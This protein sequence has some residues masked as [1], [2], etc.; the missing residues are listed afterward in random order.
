MAL[1]DGLKQVPEPMLTYHPSCSLSNGHRCGMTF[2][3]LSC[4]SACN[5]CGCAVDKAGLA[6][7]IFRCNYPTA[8][9]KLI[10]TQ[11]IRC[12]VLSHAIYKYFASK[13]CLFSGGLIWIIHKYPSGFF[14]W[15]WG[16]CMVAPVSLKHPWWRH[17]METVPSYW[18]FVWGIHRSRVN[19]PHR[20]QWRWALMFFICAW[21]NGRVNNRDAGDLR[22]YRTHYDVTVMSEGYEYSDL[23]KT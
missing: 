9:S 1:S 14:Q 23:T 18:P 17:Q 4:F 16:H 22:R 2:P 13:F 21:T 15:H 5:I 10:Q 7:M 8:I 12:R 6:V 20:S 11:Y 19:S 3:G